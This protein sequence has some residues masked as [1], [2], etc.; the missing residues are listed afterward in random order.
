MDDSSVWGLFLF[1]AFLAAAFFVVGYIAASTGWE[2]DAF[3]HGAI[4]YYI[5]GNQNKA[6]R[7]VTPKREVKGEAQ[8]AGEE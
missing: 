6:W 8:P 2:R 7:W 5:D 3:E 4:E 1:M